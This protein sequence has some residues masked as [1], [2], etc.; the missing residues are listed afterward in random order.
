MSLPPDSQ[1]SGKERLGAFIVAACLICA[2]L[3][4]AFEG[5]R[6]KPYNDPAGIKTVCY[7]E[8]EEPMRVYSEDECGVLL[9]KRLA[10]DYAPKL[11]QC[12]PQI[13]T[14]SKL[15]MFSALLD[16]SYNAGWAAVCQSPM[17]AKIKAGDF[18]GACHALTADYIVGGKLI[19][20]WYASA[21][22]RKTGVRK[23]LPGLVKRRQAEAKLC[24]ESASVVT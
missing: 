7:G 3:T 16:A 23:E 5:L 14:W 2:P 15:S 11:V 8:T 4:M 20:G 1:L 22:N 6:T 13:V 17:A 10:Q 12:L 21:K 24:L 19:H 9:R 18:V